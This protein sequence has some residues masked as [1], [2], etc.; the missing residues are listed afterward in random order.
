MLTDLD[1]SGYMG[2]GQSAAR[3][4]FGREGDGIM[5]RPPSNIRQWAGTFLV[6]A[7]VSGAMIISPLL[8]HPVQA[9]Q[10]WAPQP[11]S[12]GPPAPGAP[13]YGYAPPPVDPARA[14]I[15]ATE[16]AEADENAAAWFL[17]GCVLGVIGL[18]I[19]YVAAPTPPAAR[20]LGKSPE[21]L[22]IYMQTYQSEGRTAQFHSALWGIGTIT[23]VGVVLIIVIL[24]NQPA[25]PVY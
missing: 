7:V 5:T 3:A 21:Y 23:I 17:A 1:D 8:E 12:W 9:Q 15:E 6:V 18:V 13:A 2:L 4:T 19:A 24:R 20:L 22:A 16:D 11:Q 10:S 25:M 14:V